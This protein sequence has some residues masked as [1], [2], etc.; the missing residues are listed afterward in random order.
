MYHL[1]RQTAKQ[2]IKFSN[3]AFKIK[4]VKFFFFLGGGGGGRFTDREI[5][6]KSLKM[7]LFKTHKREMSDEKR[8]YYYKSSPRIL[9]LSQNS[10]HELVN[11]FHFCFKEDI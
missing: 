8:K 7:I 11:L 3:S 9:G 6:I 1:G 4:W 2:K 5:F 10:F